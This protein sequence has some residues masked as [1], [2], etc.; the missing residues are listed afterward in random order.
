MK[1]DVNFWETKS[2][3]GELN[4][5]NPRIMV[6]VK[7]RGPSAHQYVHFV[8]NIFSLFNF[9]RIYLFLI[10]MFADVFS[11]WPSPVR[12]FSDV[13]PIISYFLDQINLW[14]TNITYDIP[15]YRYPVKL[16]IVIST[17]C[18]PNHRRHFVYEYIIIS[19]FFTSQ[20]RFVFTK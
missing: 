14:Q 2:F 18:W 7:V 20:F 19:K 12:I 4:I 10:F 13:L 5:C 9:C 11:I 3:S 15:T 16:K 6:L 1:L 8:R 17:T